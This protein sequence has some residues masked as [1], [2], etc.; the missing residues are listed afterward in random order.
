M[1]GIL[2][3]RLDKGFVVMAEQEDRMLAGL[4]NGNDLRD[5]VSV[6]G[7]ADD[8]TQE[9]ADD[10]LIALLEADISSDEAGP[11]ESS[12]CAAKPPQEPQESVA[13]AVAAEVPA[14]VESAPREHTVSAGK[15]PLVLSGLSEAQRRVFFHLRRAA[16]RHGASRMQIENATLASKAGVPKGSIH[17]IAGKLEDAGLI[18]VDRPGAGIAPFFTVTDAGM[19]V[20]S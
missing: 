15:A 16:D 14:E 12:E 17:Y 3:R 5:W 1:D 4:S 8:D 6:W 18:D 11:A 13:E 9:A 10:Q 2:I 19:K 20:A 7:G